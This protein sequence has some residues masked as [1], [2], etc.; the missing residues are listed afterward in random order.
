MGFKQLSC[1][2]KNHF[3]DSNPADTKLI[4]NSCTIGSD[5]VVDEML[6]CFTL[7]R[8]IDWMLPNVKP[9]GKYVEVPLIAIINFR[10]GKLYN[11]NIY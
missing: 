9:I 4:P 8:E 1:F 3:V 6:F 7:D 10:G 11:E 2:Y 5:R